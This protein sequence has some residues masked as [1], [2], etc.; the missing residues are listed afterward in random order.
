MQTFRTTSGATLHLA[1][2]GVRPRRRALESELRRAIR[3]GR[4]VA[5]TR[6]PSSRVLAGDLGVARGTVVEAYTQLVAEGFLESRRGSGTWVADVPLGSEQRSQSHETRSFVR[7]NFNPGVP[8]LTAFPRTAWVRAL[9]VGLRDA[10]AASLSYGDRRGRP[11]LREALASYLGRARG[12]VADPERIVVTSG[13][14]HALSLLTRVLHAEGLRRIAMEDPCMAWHRSVASAAGLQVM[15]LPVD[16]FGARTDLLAE[17]GAGAVVLAPAHQF[18]L[19]VQ[20]HPDRRGAAISW[21]RLN[22][23]LVIEDDYDAELR[24]DRPPVGAL[25]A[26]HPDRVAYVGTA[27]KPLAPGL[28]LGWM[29]LPAELVD[30]VSK[31]RILEDVHISAPD[32][33]AFAGLLAS[34]AFERHIRRMRLRYRARRDR[35]I[36]MLRTY[37]PAVRPVGISAGLRVLLELPPGSP[38]GAALVELAH[39]ESIELFAVEPCYHREGD[40]RAGV[41]VGYTALPEHAFA[42]GLEA[43]GQFLRRHARHS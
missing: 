19:G 8:D 17:T 7:F 32:Q 15:P 4:L 14:V 24:Y 23:G 3:E 13:F 41:V 26:L 28:R 11:E 29:L 40:G 5:G 25:Q 27:S 38:S 10:P 22:E 31:L 39:A 30:R 16:G 42:Q 20:L 2:D 1:L 36:E 12:A 37:A 18:P 35:L 33:V 9:R 34:G 6:L 43:L 21:A